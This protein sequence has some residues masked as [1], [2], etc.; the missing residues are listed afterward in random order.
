MHTHRLPSCCLR[1]LSFP[2]RCACCRGDDWRPGDGKLIWPATDG[3]VRVKPEWHRPPGITFLSFFLERGFPSKTFAPESLPP[4]HVCIIK[5][6]NTDRDTERKR[7]H[8]PRARLQSL[9]QKRKWQLLCLLRFLSFVLIFQ[10]CDL[11]FF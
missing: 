5:V 4:L 6:R 1:R 2:R 10:P 3:D 8:Q 9:D 7:P 11:F